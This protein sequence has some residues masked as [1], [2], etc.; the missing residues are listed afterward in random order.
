MRGFSPVH[1]CSGPVAKRTIDVAVGGF[2]MPRTT[3]DDL[4][5]R[6]EQPSRSR[7]EWPIINWLRQRLRR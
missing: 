2:M 1:R 5:F 6:S 4:M 7:H 3:V